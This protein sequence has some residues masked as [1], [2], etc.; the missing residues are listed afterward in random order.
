V[1][2]ERDTIAIAEDF[3]EQERMK[4]WAGK[5]AFRGVWG[6]EGGGE[7]GRG[8]RTREENGGREGGG[9]QRVQN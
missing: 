6:E 7:E 3:Q 9:H 8:R 1:R 5:K 2:G 4:V